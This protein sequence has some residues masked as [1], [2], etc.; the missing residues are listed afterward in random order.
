MSPSGAAATGSSIPAP[1]ANAAADAG[2]PDGNDVEPGRRV[3]RDNHG[4]GP[5]DGLLRLKS[6]FRTAFATADV[7]PTAS[8]PRVAAR[9]PNRPPPAARTPA[10]ASHSFEWSANEL[11]G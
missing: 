3:A 6:G 1:T 4:A 7:S 2:W 11:S 5:D 10:H 9:R 8:S